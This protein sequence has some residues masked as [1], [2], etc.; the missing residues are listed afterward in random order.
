VWIASILLILV[1]LFWRPIG[2]AAFHVQGLL[3]V[4]HGAAQAAGVILVALSVRA[5]DALDLAG[6]RPGRPVRELQT[7]GPYGIV[8]HPIYLGWMLVAFGTARM[9]GD[10]LAFA[11]ISS[12]YLMIAVGWEERSLEREHGTAYREYRKKVRWRIVPYIY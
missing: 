11:A 2:G 3:A 5:I 9:T 6:I 4:V 7:R 10:R 8:R 1:C 12:A